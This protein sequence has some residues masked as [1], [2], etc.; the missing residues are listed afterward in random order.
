MKP[1]GMLITPCALL[2][3]LQPFTGAVTF[4]YR[5]GSMKKIDLLS[6]RADLYAQAS[7]PLF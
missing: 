1:N 7:L 5:K 6:R 4:T 3:N 2:I